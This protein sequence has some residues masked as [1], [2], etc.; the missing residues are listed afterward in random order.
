MDIDF[1]SLYIQ[2]TFDMH[3]ITIF[4]LWADNNE[5]YGHCIL[6]A[7]Y[8]MMTLYLHPSEQTLYSIYS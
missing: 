1:L 7:K 4:V 2:Y 5:L 3:L 6:F 8:A